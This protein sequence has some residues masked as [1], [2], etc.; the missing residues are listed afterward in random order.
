MRPG[1]RSGIV[2]VNIITINII[3][4]HGQE[5]TRRACRRLNTMQDAP[6]KVKLRSGSEEEDARCKNG[7]EDGEEVGH[8]RSR[9][10][11]GVDRRGSLLSAA[12]GGLYT[13][14]GAREVGSES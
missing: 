14:G 9:G 3:K 6:K 8:S 4:K 5:M 2:E 7:H 12:R 13:R 10:S 1:K 11:T